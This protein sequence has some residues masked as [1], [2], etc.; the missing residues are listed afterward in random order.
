MISSQSGH[1]PHFAANDQSHGP[2]QPPASAEPDGLD[3]LQATEGQ[4]AHDDLRG[5][6]LHHLRQ[7]GLDGLGCQRMYGGVAVYH[8]G[9]LFALVAH[10]EVYFRVDKHNIEPYRTRRM[11]L[12]RTDDGETWPGFFKVPDEVLDQPDTLMAWASG[13]LSAANRQLDR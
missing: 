4:F 7:Q 13:A 11:P 6:V 3:R 10:R 12:F 2:A 8:H 9:V 1:A 5:R